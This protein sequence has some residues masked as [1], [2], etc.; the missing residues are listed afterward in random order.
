[1]RDA[2]TPITA[3]SASALI[4]ALVGSV[5]VPSGALAQALVQTIERDPPANYERFG[6]GRPVL[7]GEAL[8][9]GVPFDDFFN[10]DGGVVY[11]YVR[12]G[13]RFTPN[14]LIGNETMCERA[15]L[16][17]TNVLIQGDTMV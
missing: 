9:L 11:H 14:G 16:F 5:V 2:Q 8:L 17:G 7:D 10:S 15:G 12:E 1:M 13:D 3:L 4:L 6:L